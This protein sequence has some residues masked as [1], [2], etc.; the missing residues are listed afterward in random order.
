MP[1]VG[2]SRTAGAD[3]ARRVSGL[4]GAPP[5]GTFHGMI[6]HFLARLAGAGRPAVAATPPGAL[7]RVGGFDVYL[8]NSRPDIDSAEVLARLADALALIEQYQPIRMR[9]L[10][11][12][13]AR[14]WVTR[15]ACRGAYFAGSRTIMTELTFLAR[16]DITAATVASSILHEGV[17][18]RVD[19]MGVAEAGRN[20]A[21][22]ERLCRRAELAF[23]EALPPA[24]GAPV[25]ER[26]LATLQMDD[27]DVAPVIDP[28]VAQARIDAVDRS[29]GMNGS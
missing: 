29:A 22:E 21:R 18:A 6:R 9:H 8:D 19:V 7:H 25:L 13:V 4:R 12:D 10:R 16:R 26:A 15:Y 24:L 27:L 28:R 11:R 5:P 17:H 2:V 1:G 3:H 23:G 20:R 14:F